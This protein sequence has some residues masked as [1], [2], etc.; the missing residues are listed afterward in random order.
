M[1]QQSHV[2]QALWKELIELFLYF[3]NA[4]TATDY[5]TTFPPL[6]VISQ[7]WFSKTISMSNL[8]AVQTLFKS[9]PAINST[10]QAAAKFKQEIKVV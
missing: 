8:I 6:L 2:E 7:V 3:L 5:C 1:V 4:Q 10:S 9:V